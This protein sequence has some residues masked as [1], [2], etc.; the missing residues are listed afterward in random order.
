MQDETTLLETVGFGYPTE[1]TGSLR[2]VE[3]VAAMSFLRG[4]DGPAHEVLR[5]GDNLPARDSILDFQGMITGTKDGRHRGWHDLNEEDKTTR[6]AQ[7]LVRDRS[8]PRKATDGKRPEPRR[9]RIYPFMVDQ[10]ERIG[11]T[12]TDKKRNL[13]TD[14]PDAE[15][16]LDDEQFYALTPR[17]EGGYRLT[18]FQSDTR[19][20]F[21][22]FRAFREHLN[23]EQPAG[24]AVGQS[25]CPDKNREQQTFLVDCFPLH[26]PYEREFLK[27]KF[28]NWHKVCSCDILSLPL[29]RIEGY[30][31]SEAALY[32]GWLRAYTKALILPA[33]FGVLLQLSVWG[34]GQPFPGTTNDAG[35]WLVAY[36]VFIAVWSSV[37][38]LSWS[39]RQSELSHRWGLEMV[40]E[41]AK[42]R[43]EFVE[44]LKAKSVMLAT[45]D[46][47]QGLIKWLKH[48][49][50]PVETISRMGKVEI[51]YASRTAHV[52]RKI[53]TLLFLA[54]GAAIV[55]FT[56]LGVLLMRARG[57]NVV[58]GS[59]SAW[60]SLEFME[61]DGFDSF[62]HVSDVSVSFW[63]IYDNS[64]GS[65]DS[66]EERVAAGDPMFNRTYGFSKSTTNGSDVRYN[67]RVST[68]MLVRRVPK[69]VDYRAQLLSGEAFAAAM[70]QNCTGSQS[71]VGLERVCCTEDDHTGSKTDSAPCWTQAKQDLADSFTMLEGVEVDTPTL[72]DRVA[73]EANIYFNPVA[74][75]E[76]VGT[77]LPYA[78]LAQFIELADFEED[79]DCV[80]TACSYSHSDLE[81]ASVSSA[82]L[83]EAFK[84]V[85]AADPP[86][87][88]P[89]RVP[90]SEPSCQDL[91]RFVKDSRDEIAAM[92]EDRNAK[93]GPL[94]GNKDVSGWTSYGRVYPFLRTSLA[95]FRY[96]NST[97]VPANFTGTRCEVYDTDDIEPSCD[98]PTYTTKAACEA[99]V[100]MWN[101]G[102]T[103]NDELE[104]VVALDATDGVIRA[105]QLYQGTALYTRDA[106]KTWGLGLVWGSTFVSVAAM[107]IFGRLWDFVATFLNNFENHRT[108]I[109]YEDAY[110]NKQFVF[111]FINYYFLLIYVAFLKMGAPLSP[112]LGDSVAAF[113]EYKPDTLRPF[114]L[115]PDI[116]D[117]V[118][119]AASTDEVPIIDLRDTCK[120]DSQGQPDCM[121]ELCM[122]L[123]T[124]FVVKQVLLCHP[125]SLAFHV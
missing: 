84:F 54:I 43:K 48:W 81:E 50:N 91:K 64:C 1:V 38:M 111:Q 78:A 107:Q 89:R 67:W 70:L 57:Q 5:D 100:Q 62:G 94:P 85:E 65:L 101:P 98:I 56:S 79:F 69:I 77:M 22:G 14:G 17:D 106:D 109:E 19:S 13:L 23:E 113:G 117:R 25:V 10:C 15:Q 42:P 112:V 31:G 97:M 108:Q 2:N 24:L 34:R 124:L 82:G 28:A 55:V 58:D 102:V 110:I 74:D 8:N 18:H 75:H 26:C 116:E 90:L 33:F 59:A 36:C 46:K 87:E 45:G 114:S 115:L 95:L 83:L 61:N 92:G 123:V 7:G 88:I 93:I 35:W 4:P 119:G 73:G 51:D 47:S 103:S 105:Q 32:F 80:E 122:Q 3:K 118:V 68:E 39:R 16:N 37:F 121:S 40:E 104:E 20:D 66:C 9:L 86:P 60:T 30:F 44:K 11:D 12:V 72:A 71:V 96:P 52:M 99:A 120:L 27:Y 49:D 53:V 6:A 125:A 29:N 76:A 21:S 63:T 41:Y